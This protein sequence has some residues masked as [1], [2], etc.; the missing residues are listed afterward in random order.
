MDLD[1]L[2]N[3]W[4]EFDRRLDRIEE[5][6]R[7]TA[8]RIARGN[9]RSG[10][11][12]LALSF[13]I[14]AVIALLATALVFFCSRTLALPGW[15]TAAFMVYLVCMGMAAFLFSRRVGRHDFLGEPTVRAV[16]YALSL[17]RQRLALVA[18]GIVCGAAVLAAFF[19]VLASKDL[20]RAIWGGMTGLAIGAAAG[21]M[22]F[23]H[24]SRL[25]RQL[26]AELRDMQ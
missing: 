24:Q 22:K 21:Y 25:L 11:Q 16:E 23:R 18:A 7:Q 10:L 1:N 17:R 6:S 12:K 20:Q 19:F 3:T 9:V 15:L 5:E 4:K 8:L 26:T 2:K 13:R 14:N